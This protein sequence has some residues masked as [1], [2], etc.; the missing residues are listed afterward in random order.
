MLGVA[1]MEDQYYA[2]RAT[3]RHLL[4]THPEWTQQEVA[5]SIGRSVAWV[6]KWVKRLRAAPPEETRV[7][8]SRSRRNNQTCYRR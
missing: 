1:A 6:K 4:R 2:D 3:L 7:L 8:W 5:A